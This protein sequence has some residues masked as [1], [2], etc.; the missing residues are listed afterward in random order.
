MRR[1]LKVVTLVVAVVPM[2]LGAGL[3][4]ASGQLLFPSWKG[5][6]ADLSHCPPELAEAWGPGCGNLRITHE[7]RFVEQQ[8]PSVLGYDLPAWWVRSDDNGAGPSR[9]AILLV[10]GGGG[11]RRS[12]TRFI[13][14]LLEQRLD[15]LAVDLGCQGEAPC[16]VRGLSYGARES[17]DVFSAFA[18]LRRTQAR[19]YAMGSSVGAAAILTALP[20]M[21]DLAGVVAENPMASFDAL[22]RNARE[23]QGMPAWALD[24]MLGLAMARGRFDGL[25]SPQHSL[26]LPSRVPVLFVHSTQDAVVSHTQTQELVA[27]YQGPHTAW[28]PSKGAHAGIWEAERSAYEDHLTAFLK[29]AD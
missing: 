26:R 7:F 28:F 2:L 1:G 18:F 17:R 27:L 19:V 11:D 10:P 12:L 25:P 8:V 13:R 21:P 15:V 5:A 16:P 20:E 4:N 6:T 29:V 23:A 14:F 24:G 9:G 3:W 22:I